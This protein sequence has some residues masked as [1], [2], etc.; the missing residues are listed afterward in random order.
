MPVES[1]DFDSSGTE[2]E[3][4]RDG[5]ARDRPGFVRDRYRRSQRS[6][7]VGHAHWRPNAEQLRQDGF[8]SP[9]FTFRFLPTALLVFT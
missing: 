4:E 3:L 1:G 9:H 8:S 2:L 7:E 5:S 6:V